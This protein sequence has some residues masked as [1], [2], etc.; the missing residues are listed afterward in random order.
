MYDGPNRFSFRGIP[1]AVPVSDSES[2]WTHSRP[3]VSLNECYEGKF[4]AHDQQEDDDVEETT[5]AANNETETTEAT[6]PAAS[7]APRGECYRR[8]PGGDYVG[9]EN[10]LFLDVFTPNLVYNE[11]MPVVVYVNGEDLHEDEDQELRP[12]SG[13]EIERLSDSQTF[14][15][16]SLPV[17]LMMCYFSFQRSP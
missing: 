2:R 3:A 16:L 10:C 12:S 8:T 14:V 13:K 17:F 15:R 7:V 1:F 4:F 11:L 5:A 9:E 6:E